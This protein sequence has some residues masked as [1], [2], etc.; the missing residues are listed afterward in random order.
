[1]NKKLPEYLTEALEE[2]EVDKDATPREL[3]EAIVRYE[4]GSDWTGSIFKWL[5]DCGYTVEVA[6]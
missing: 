1:M 2:M 6:E 3:F 4:F 5:R